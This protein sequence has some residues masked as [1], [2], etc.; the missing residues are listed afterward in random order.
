MFNVTTAG[1][2]L[3]IEDSEASGGGTNRVVSL[4]TVRFVDVDGPVHQLVRVVVPS[5][6]KKVFDYVGTLEAGSVLATSGGS[7][8]VGTARDSLVWRIY[9]PDTIVPIECFEDVEA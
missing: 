6:R 4:E 5:R 1:K 9:S 8:S 2:I 7:F 3:F